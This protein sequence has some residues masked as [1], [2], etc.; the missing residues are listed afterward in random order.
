MGTFFPL[1]EV[2]TFGWG[3]IYPPN[4]QKFRLRRTKKKGRWFLRKK[5]YY[6]EKI[7]IPPASFGPEVWKVLGEV[8][9]PPYPPTPMSVQGVQNVPR[10]APASGNAVKTDAASKT[11]NATSV[12]T[13]QFLPTRCEVHSVPPVPLV[14]RY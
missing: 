14:R 3:S 2:A 10:S 13:G 1:G 9:T 4:S 7:A 6:V 11:A 5:F 12:E 8:Y